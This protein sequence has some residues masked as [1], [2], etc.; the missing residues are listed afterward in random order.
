[1]E[2]ANVF[3]LTPVQQDSSWIHRIANALQHVLFNVILLTLLTQPNVLVDVLLSPILAL[4]VNSRIL[5]VVHALPAHLHA[6]YPLQPV[7]STLY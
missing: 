7:Q 6:Q 2:N 1:M 4:Q 5:K 3:A